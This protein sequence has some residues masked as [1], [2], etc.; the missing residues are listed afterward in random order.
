MKSEGEEIKVGEEESVENTDNNE[1]SQKNDIESRL[2][3]LRMKIN[4]GRKANT[5]EVQEEVSI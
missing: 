1:K 3:N 5:A 4:Q 2:F